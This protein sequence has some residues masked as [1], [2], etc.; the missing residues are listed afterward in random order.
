M[1]IL[2]ANEAPQMRFFCCIS[3]LPALLK[4]LKEFEGND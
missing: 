4:N 2:Y 3:F 1:D